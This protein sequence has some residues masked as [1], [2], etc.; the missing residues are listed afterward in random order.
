M[1]QNGNGANAGQYYA[2]TLAHVDRVVRGWGN[3]FAYGNAPNTLSTLDEKI[4][5]KL[6]R[7]EKW[8]R[9]C[10]SGIDSKAK[11]RASG[12]GLLGDLK[13]KSLSDLPFQLE[14]TRRYRRTKN[15]IFASTDGSVFRSKS[16][17][18]GKGPGGWAVV[19]EDGK[20][21]VGRG[22]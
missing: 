15:T 22:D 20:C 12:V 7:F 19:F 13:E 6:L 21:L 1:L 8:Y 10:I 16:R 11:R 2:Q 17:D 4:D 14:A 18:R 5:E 3:S 9:K